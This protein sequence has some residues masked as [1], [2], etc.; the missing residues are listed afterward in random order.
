MSVL[1]GRL[2][3]VGGNEFRERVHVVASNLKVQWDDL[4]GAADCIVYEIDELMQEFGLEYDDVSNLHEVGGVWYIGLQQCI[5]Y[6]VGDR[7]FVMVTPN[8]PWYV[9]AFLREY[10]DLGI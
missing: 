10:K 8:K 6:T 9:L 2:G 4:L 3:E 1:L 5:W 7:E